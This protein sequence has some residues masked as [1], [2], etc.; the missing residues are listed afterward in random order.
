MLIPLSW[1]VSEAVA[2]PERKRR[3]GWGGG[4]GCSWV[5][6]RWRECVQS[7]DGEGSGS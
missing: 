5:D 6:G 3:R 2:M 7:R 1:T 4:G